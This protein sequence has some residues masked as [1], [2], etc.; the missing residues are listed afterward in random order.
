MNALCLG[1]DNV[2][3]AKIALF[4][5]IDGGLFRQ[6]AIDLHV[7]RVS[8]VKLG[9]PKLLSGDIDI[10][11]GNSGPV[12]EAITNQKSDL[13]VIASLGPAS[14]A[15]FT[16]SDITTPESL[17]GKRFGVSTP[18]ASQ[19]RIARRALKRMRL[20]PEKDIEVV[21][22][23]FNNS[24]ER[25]AALARGEVDAVIG[26]LENYPAF[27]ELPEEEGQKIGKLVDLEDLGIHISGSD[28]SATRGF[29]QEKRNLAHRF[30]LALEQSLALTKQ[31]PDVVS[32][33]F[34]IHL[35]LAH[36]AAV[37]AKASGYYN[38]RLPD[39]PLPDRLAIQNNLDELREKSPG[40]V[41]PEL[42]EC[43]DESLF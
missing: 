31:R 13:V 43:I 5:G 7:E 6:A 11:V 38:L 27:P 33:A 37:A 14:F 15:V 26:G 29:L 34:K 30:L 21:Y 17:K 4:A 2:E 3:G 32:E 41:L 40:L 20:E 35:Q 24:T 16:R 1:Y 25:L 9:V 39:R 36:P 18:G 42:A 22:T 23:G 19:D 10:L 8:P 28:I 12:I